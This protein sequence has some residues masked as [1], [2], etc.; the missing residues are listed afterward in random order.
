MN[1]ARIQDAIDRLSATH[2]TLT[3]GSDTLLWCKQHALYDVLDD[4]RELG[5]NDKA[6]RLVAER[7]ALIFRYRGCRVFTERLGSVIS[8]LKGVLV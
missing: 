5:R 4:L 1:K 3:T 2:E 6:V 8:E 7:L